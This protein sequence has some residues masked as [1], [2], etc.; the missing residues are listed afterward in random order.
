MKIKYGI[1]EKE[2][3]AARLCIEYAARLG[4][5]GA[6]VTLSK[7][8]LDTV[9]L[10]NGGIDKVTHCADRSIYL[11]LFID[12]RYG[13]YSTN[14]IDGAGLEEFVR[15]AAE[16]TRMLAKDQFR[17]LPEASRCEKGAL[18]GLELGLYDTEYATV[19]PR[20]RMEM[21]MRGSIF[22]EGTENVGKAGTGDGAQ[23][24]DFSIISEECEWS[25]SVDDNYVI[26]SQGFEGRHIETSFSF[27]TE[28]TICAK[29]GKKYSGYSWNASPRL[30]EVSAEGCSQEALEKA[31]AQMNPK[32]VKSG[33]RTMVV[34]CNSSSRL[35]APLLSALN[36]TAVQQK[37]SFLEGSLGKKVFSGDF[38]LDDLARTCGKSGSRLFD[39]EGVATADRT[40]IEGGVVRMFFVNTY[41]AGKTG[42]EPTVEGVSRPVVRP[43]SAIGDNNHI[44]S[45]TLTK[46]EIMKQC[47]EGILVTGFNGGNCNQ[48]TGDFS[49]GIEGFLFRKG[50]IVHPVKEMVIT[51]NMV[52]LWNS[53]VAAGSDPREGTRW[54]IPTLAFKDVTFNS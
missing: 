16:A 52:D 9:A 11:Y 8:V 19:T 44:V 47:G 20:Q 27:W 34:D 1:T 18:T 32:R 33:K 31:V 23:T 30:K 15:R 37:N 3:E 6:R 13:T 5:E 17:R 51:G 42:M 4:A 25:D 45:G 35:V 26:D 41:M 28:V 12:G 53:V 14:L 46:E 38:Y 43:F 10:L 29:D 49:Y 36:A 39:T 22:S 2:I 24:D 48:T 40:L 7:N 50:R 54:Q 21:A